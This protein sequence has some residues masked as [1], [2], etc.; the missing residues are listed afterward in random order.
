MKIMRARSVLKYF[1][2]LVVLSITLSL[3]WLR[4]ESGQPRDEWFTERQGQ[5]KSAEGS[6][7]KNE[8]GQLAESVQLV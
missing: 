8:Y 6:I 1:V 4:W 3:V 5:I 2:L 7:S